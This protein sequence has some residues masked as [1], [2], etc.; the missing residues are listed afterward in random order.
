[1]ITQEEYRS[2]RNA[3]LE[4][5]KNDSVAIVVS[6]LPSSRSNDTE[7]PYRQNSSFYYLCGFKED[8]AALL[9]L[10]SK[11]ETKTLLFVQ[12][13]EPTME[14]W[15]GKRLGIDAARALFLVDD[16]Y[17]FDEL[18]AKLAE[19][20]KKKSV[21]YYD[22]GMTNPAIARF[23]E[24]T[25]KFYAHYNLWHLIASMRL[26]KSDSE[27]ALIR[28]ALEITKEAHHNALRFSK[29]GKYEYELQAEFEYIFK[30]NGAYSDAYTSIVAGG[31]GANT[32]HYIAN[33]RR[34]QAGELLLIDAG[35]E[36][37]YYAS[38][39]TRTIPVSG[40]FSSAQRELYEMVLGVELEIIAMIK[41]GVK[42]SELQKRAEELLTIGMVDLGI[43]Q[44][45]VRKLLSTKAH[46]KYFPHGIGHWMGL[47]VHD[48]A[49]YKEQNGKEIPLAE[50]MVLTIEPGIYIDEND[51][52][53]P[54]RFRGIGIR[55]EDD[56][57]VSAEGHVNLSEGIAKGIE[58]IERL[59][60]TY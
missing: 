33:N 29:V 5:L 4:E 14:L 25:K 24:L 52:S 30:K 45:R 60:Q 34:M 40:R 56:I 43:L 3:L 21:A 55:I 10:K 32:L 6:A 59:S 49:P 28:K 11:K 13:K 31:N 12:K 53:V 9:F 17:G 18:E 35:C 54:E 27:I 1:M 38:D 41:P 51:Q 36:Y 48:E 19:S 57:L 39:I 58:E 2:R 8:N 42:R 20:V 46:K 16:V 26:V 15:S 44:G 50:G 23:K 7:F 47:D 37:E 22:F